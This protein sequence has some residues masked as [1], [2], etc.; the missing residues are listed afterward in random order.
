MRESIVKALE[1]GIQKGLNLDG[2]EDK[3]FGDIRGQLEFFVRKMPI[4]QAVFNWKKVHDFD[5]L[6]KDSWTM[7]C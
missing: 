5:R 7:K 4:G 3:L 6:E 1:Y 2:Y